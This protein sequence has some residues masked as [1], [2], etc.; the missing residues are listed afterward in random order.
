MTD[1]LTSRAQ[2]LI[3]EFEEGASTRHGIANV[4][5]HLANNY[6]DIESWYA[7]PASTL[8][9]LAAELTAPTVLDRALAGDKAAAR[10]FL[11]EAGFTDANGQLRP[12][13]APELYSDD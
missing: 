6:G 2:R 7:V 12:P 13:Y 1:H 11:Y 8:V 5:T 3:D 9:Q 10:Q 4:L